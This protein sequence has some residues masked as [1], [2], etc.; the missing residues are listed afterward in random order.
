MTKP[1]LEQLVKSLFDDYLDI[2]EE[3]DEGRLFHPIHVSCCRAMK[4]EPLNK[5][6]R[7]MKEL[8]NNDNTNN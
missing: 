7:Q 1:T 6:L 8:A 2:V 5:L 3:S 4:T